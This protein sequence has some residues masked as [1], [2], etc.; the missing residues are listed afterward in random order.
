[1]LNSV[2]NRLSLGAGSKPA[3][4]PYWEAVAKQGKRHTDRRLPNEPIDIIKTLRPNESKE[5]SD[6]RAKNERQITRTG[7][8]MFVSKLSRI[9]SSASIRTTGKSDEVEKWLATMP[10]VQMGKN[11]NLMGFAYECVLKDALSNPNQLVVAFPYN[12]LNP[13][14]HPN[15]SIQ[16]GGLSP[17]QSVSIEIKFIPYEKINY[18]DSDVLVF[19]GGY[20]TIARQSGSKATVPFYYAADK[21]NWYTLEPVLNTKGGYDYEAVIWY[22][23]NTGESLVN[24]LPGEIQK[25]KD[26][27]TFLESYI[28][29]YYDW[30]D[31]VI[32]AF[33][34]DQGTRSRFSSP[35]VGVTATDCDAQGC[36]NGYLDGKRDSPCGSCSGTGKKLLPGPY[37]VYHKPVD[38]GMVG[39]QASK[40]KDIEFYVP[41]TEILDYSYRTWKDLYK[42]AK[43]SIGLDLLDGTGVES[44]NAKDLRLEDLQDQLQRISNGLF[45]FLENLLYQVESLLVLDDGSRSR[46][47]F[48]VPKRFRLDDTNDL[49]EQARE[50]LPE[51]RFMARMDYYQSKY[52]GNPEKVRLFELAMSYAPSMLLNEDEFINRQASGVYGENEGIKRGSAVIA[53]QKIS[54]D[55]TL[56]ELSEDEAFALIDAYLIDRGM[57]APVAV[58]LLDGEES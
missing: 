44:G 43:Q 55:Y 19:K 39:S 6:Y 50:A 14:V 45:S 26:G 31:E 33:S 40:G 7:Y 48:I 8:D 35:F 2:I 28:R 34:D 53:L 3:P 5:V 47:K 52:V 18:V 12:E 36:R 25:Q 54:K 37:E 20:R 21:L 56:T 42:I 46:V 57:F 27:S 23:H 22:I 1:M 58:E 29:P 17:A 13:D 38:D 9:F 41:P 24:F 30:A 51:E 32:S 4:Y 11:F 16:D 10:F 49:A 15:F